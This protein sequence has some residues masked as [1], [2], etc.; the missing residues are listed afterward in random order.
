MK[1]LLLIIFTLTLIFTGCKDDSSTPY[2]QI[3]GAWQW[4]ESTGGIAGLQL[5]PG[6]EGY[7]MM[8]VFNRNGTYKRIVADT[9]FSEV[10]WPLCLSDSP[11]RQ[12]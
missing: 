2:G 10:S 9:V 7:D 8:L 3:Y 1:K 12:S 6:T 11:T 4:V 5:T